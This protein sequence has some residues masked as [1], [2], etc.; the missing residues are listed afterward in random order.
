MQ[1]KCDEWIELAEE[2]ILST[3]I[4]I[5]QWTRRFCS[6]KIVDDLKWMAL[7]NTLLLQVDMTP[8]DQKTE[9]KNNLIKDVVGTM[10]KILV[11]AAK[12]PGL[13]PYGF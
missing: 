2:F 7:K 5:R 12:Q 3:K 1:E 4:D 8:H 9:M 10:E 6:N 13:S 11:C